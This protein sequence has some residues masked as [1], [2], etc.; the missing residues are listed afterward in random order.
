M[1]SKSLKDFFKNPIIAVP[2][3]LF[4]LIGAILS[5]NLTNSKSLSILENAGRLGDFTTVMAEA[6][7]VFTFALFLIIFTIFVTPFIMSWSNLMCKDIINGEPANFGE[8]FRD[9]WKYYWRMLGAIVI[10]VLIFIGLAAAAFLLM[11]PF[12]LL[13]VGGRSTSA[14]GFAI[15]V[16]IVLFFAIIFF[17]ISLTAVEPI[18][19][20]DNLGIGESIAKGFKFGIKKFFPIL[21][22]ALLIGIVNGILTLIFDKENYFSIIINGYLGLFITVFIMNMYREEKLKTEVSG[23][24][25][26]NSSETTMDSIPGE[27]PGAEVKDTSNSF[28]GNSTDNENVETSEAHEDDKENPENNNR[29]RL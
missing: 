4:A 9:S 10:K 23:E 17:A 18:L 1:F 13:S 8:R 7:K 20:F 6:V 26:Y 29:F 16:I 2:N 24:M 5:K 28:I 14:A 27:T 11:L 21:G 19:I 3:V 12:G 25:P 22:T 15:I